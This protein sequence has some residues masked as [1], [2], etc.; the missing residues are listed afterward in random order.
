[1][2]VGEIRDLETAQVAI[3]SALTG[4]MILSTLHTNSAASSVTRLLDM[5]VE[6][7]LITSTLN[8]V[9]AQRLVRRLCPVCRTPEPASEATLLALGLSPQSSAPISFFHAKGC[10]ACGNSGFKGRVALFE[11]L[12]MDDEIARLVLTRAEARE[13]QRAAVSAGMRTMLADGIV[14]ART[15]S[16]TIDEVLRVTREA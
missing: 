14:K 9:L 7:F 8:A 5:G 12:P 4:H 2:M 11:L 13:I 15:G 3:Q 6:P 1:M 16:T 10:G